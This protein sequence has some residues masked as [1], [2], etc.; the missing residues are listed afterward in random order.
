MR[1]SILF[2]ATAAASMLLTAAPVQSQQT[3]MDG[4][5]PATLGEV[6]FEISC[7]A[8]A[9][10]EF[11]TGLLL[12]HH[13][14]YRMAEARF[15]AA[16]E[17]D[18]A[19]SMAQWGIA[20]SNF[21]PLWP[22][23][24]SP[25]EREDGLAAI[26]RA[27]GLDPGTPREQAYLD[28]AVR[29]YDPNLETYP[30]RRTAWS[31]AQRLVYTNHPDDADAAAF[32]ALAMLAVA[33]PGPQGLQLQ[34]DA[35]AML[36]E[37]SDGAPRHPGALH[38]L[39]HAY[40]S[41]PMAQAA[42][43]F[44]EAYLN[45][46]P[47]NPHALH[48]PS[49]IMTRLGRWEEAAD[50]N[51]RS[52]DAVLAQQMIDG[53]VSNHYPHA[54]DYLTYAQ[55]QLGLVD[56]AAAT[57]AE[58]LGTSDMQDVFGTAYAVAAAPARLA[59]EQENWEAAANLP[60]IPYEGLEWD[61]YPHALAIVA[62]AKG[63]GAARSGADT[64]A[65]LA[66]LAELRSVMDERGMGYWVTLADA[67]I[68]AVE[69]WTTFEAGDHNAA[70]AAM[71]AAANTEDS[72]GKAPVT[73]SHVL[74]VREQFGDLLLLLEEPEAAIAAYETALAVSPNRLRSLAGINEASGN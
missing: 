28:A 42:L 13:M 56:E 16:A 7:N 23:I 68:G 46:A 63:I 6:D 29:F 72:V 41:P 1:N 18:A 19:C 12:L 30:E 54:L 10:E 8:S 44:V 20:M 26:S 66:R 48:M 69:A 67:Q 59:L 24:Q 39:I 65:A 70:R 51:R 38:Y 73:P 5:D 45:L 14:M 62:F 60:D 61:R 31:E 47:E 37:L 58:L 2:P 71:E 35:G 25:T 21:H 57:V 32:A 22:G 64:S 17:A 4:A 9:Q 11:E 40:D 52:A 33:P 3:A 53:A 27:E 15:E 43:P 36:E 34:Q 50:L 74:P 49:H 55:L